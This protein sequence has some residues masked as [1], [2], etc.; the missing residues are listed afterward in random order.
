MA[1]PNKY[2]TPGLLGGCLLAFI[3]WVAVLLSSVADLGNSPT[4]L[5]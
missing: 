3:D 5:L 1:W 2:V 4:L